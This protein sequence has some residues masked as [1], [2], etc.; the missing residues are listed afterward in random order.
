MHPTSINQPSTTMARYWSQ[1][2]RPKD[3]S[4]TIPTA[5]KTYDS[6][7]NLNL[8]SL[9]W[10][11]GHANCGFAADT[12]WYKADKSHEAGE[13]VA[14]VKL[15]FNLD[16]RVKKHLS[17]VECHLTFSQAPREQFH[18]VHRCWPSTLRGSPNTEQVSK[19]LDL[20]PAAEGM[21]F[22][23]SIGGMHVNKEKTDQS[24]WVF[25]S[26]RRVS[27]SATAARYDMVVLCWESRCGNDYVSF[28]G[29]E[30]Y[31]ATVL[32][33]AEGDLILSARLIAKRSQNVPNLRVSLASKKDAT[34]SVQI[35]MTTGASDDDLDTHGRKAMEWADNRNDEAIPKGNLKS[36]L[37][38][39]RTDNRA[40]MA[41]SRSQPTENR[42]D[43][44]P[45]SGRPEVLPSTSSA[46]DRADM[47]SSKS[48]SVDERAEI[49]N[50]KPAKP[51]DTS[52]KTGHVC[53][54][55]DR[56]LP[57]GR[58]GFLRSVYIC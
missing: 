4:S 39:M 46:N 56:A 2:G 29:R 17:R 1:F 16:H 54:C 47:A 10:K 27:D 13:G 58:S 5:I 28:S 12:L 8:A 6:C 38:W 22:G 57:S 50:S 35:T 21:G 33:C 18:G 19:G 37:S 40:E 26:Q 14:V 20:T 32:A 49:T 3:K 53:T 24:N 41:N 30:L 36:R 48:A 7:L 55:N 23:G 52:Q 15:S 25:T 43:R 42:D 44:A 9:D 45:P 51:D 11:D 34:A 31:A